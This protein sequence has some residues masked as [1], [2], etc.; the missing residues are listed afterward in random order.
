MANNADSNG[1]QDLDLENPQQ[2]SINQLMDG[3]EQQQDLAIENIM[4]TKSRR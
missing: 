2:P 1:T 4:E 3:V